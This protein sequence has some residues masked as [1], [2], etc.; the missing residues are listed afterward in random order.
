[1]KNLILDQETWKSQAV[2]L[3]RAIKEKA[4]IYDQIKLWHYKKS[5]RNLQRM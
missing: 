1:M 5:M 2:K 3:E 4:S